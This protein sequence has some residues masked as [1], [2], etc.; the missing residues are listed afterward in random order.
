MSPAGSLDTQAAAVPHPFVLAP[1]L[2]LRCLPCTTLETPLSASLH[3]SRLM[4]ASVYNH[5]MVAQGDTFR[6]ARDNDFHGMIFFGPKLRK[7]KIT[8]KFSAHFLIYLRFRKNPLMELFVLEGFVRFR[9]SVCEK[10][11]FERAET[12]SLSLEIKIITTRTSSLFRRFHFKSYSS[13]MTV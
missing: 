8:T 10:K 4:S 2:R 12:I 7:K 5:P 11:M 3:N 9:I 6:C 13:P 1:V